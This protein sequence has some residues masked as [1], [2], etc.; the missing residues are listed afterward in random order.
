MSGQTILLT[1]LPLTWPN[2]PPIG[3]GYLQAFLAQK[4]ISADLI[5]FNQIFI[6]FQTINCKS[7]G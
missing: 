5:D 6:P 7:S 1:I 4:G 3:L 2:M